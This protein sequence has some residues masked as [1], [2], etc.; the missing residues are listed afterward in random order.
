M[1]FEVFKKNS[2][3]KELSKEIKQNLI[4]KGFEETK[5]SFI[6]PLDTL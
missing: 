6:K 4:N 5:D 3:G 1:Y 2:Y